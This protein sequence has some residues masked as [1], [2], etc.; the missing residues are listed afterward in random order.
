MLCRWAKPV[1]IL[2][3]ITFN[4]YRLTL[5]EQWRELIFSPEAAMSIDIS[6]QFGVF[7]KVFCFIT[8]TCAIISLYLALQ[9]PANS[10]FGCHEH[11]L[12]S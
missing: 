4:A 3:P 11:M 5:L 12:Y 2:V 8:G 6:G 7:D 9:V 1:R 10:S